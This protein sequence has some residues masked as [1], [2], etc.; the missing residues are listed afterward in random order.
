MPRVITAE[1]I[2]ANADILGIDYSTSYGIYIEDV[3]GRRL[4]RVASVDLDTGEVEIVTHCDLVDADTI[5]PI[6]TKI[7]LNYFKL[8]SGT[9]YLEYKSKDISK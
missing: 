2:Q 7:K 9:W 1:D 6:K 3:A 5:E 8:V 4:E